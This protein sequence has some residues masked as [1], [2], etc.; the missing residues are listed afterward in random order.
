MLHFREVSKRILTPLNL[1]EICGKNLVGAKLVD[2]KSSDHDFRVGKIR[3]SLM[4]SYSNLN[5]PKVVGKRS[6]IIPNGG[7]EWP[8]SL[9]VESIKYHL[10]KSKLSSSRFA[11]W[12]ISPSFTSELFSSPMSLHG[13]L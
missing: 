6:K 2:P 8:F 1:G 9:V 5:L 11:L 13:S 7:E 4:L 10:N 3:T 12:S